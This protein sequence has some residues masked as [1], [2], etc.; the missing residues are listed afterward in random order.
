MSFIFFY[1]LPSGY[2][3]WLLATIGYWLWLL[4]FNATLQPILLN[5]TLQCNPD[6]TNFFDGCGEKVANCNGQ[7][8]PIAYSL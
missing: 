1:P 7:G 3:Y 2:F 8:K 4:S 6:F 5:A